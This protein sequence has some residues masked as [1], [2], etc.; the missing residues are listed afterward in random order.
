MKS[1]C[2]IWAVRQWWREGGY[3]A[4]RKSSY[5]PFPHFVWTPT[6]SS[7]AMSF[8]PVRPRRRLLPPL[9]FRGRVKIGD[10]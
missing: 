9:I 1:N 10:P 6:V 5:G 3:V 8:V 4:A 2:F 7:E